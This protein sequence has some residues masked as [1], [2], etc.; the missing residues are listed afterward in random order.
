MDEKI[1]ILD[2]RINTFT[3]NSLNELISSIC[4]NGRKSIIA[5][6]NV[7]AI[8]L[9]CEQNWLRDFFNKS[10]YVFC[11]GHGVMLGA[12]LQG[13]RLPQK[14]TYAHWFPIFCS[15]CVTKD[16]SLY[17]LGG[18]PGVANK[19]K[20]NLV[21]SYPGLKV[22]GTHD[23]YFNKTMDS[24]EN[25]EVID[26]INSKKPNVVLVSFGMPLQEKWLSE[27]WNKVNANV[28]L[29]GGAALDYMAG[30]AK[31]PPH[32]LTSFGFE[33]LGRMFYEPN[34]LWKRYLIGNPQFITRIIL[35]VF[36]LRIL[37]RPWL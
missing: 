4:L 14:I 37:K 8:N 29:T 7:H 21:A 1:K 9:A 19:A 26:D 32:W 2:I 12:Q 18:R 10:D 6:V 11:D 3:I 35:E 33:W 16:L 5:N 30:I 28:A 27:N 25:Q 20:E 24:T 15:F 31:R 23:G 34:R 13:K 17:F 22:V 36:Y